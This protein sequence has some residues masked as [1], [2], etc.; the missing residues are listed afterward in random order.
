MKKSRFMYS[1][2]V[3]NESHKQRIQYSKNINGT[4]S[5]SEAVDTS[6]FLL[7]VTGHRS[8]F[9]QYR[10]Y[11]KHLEKLTLG[12]IRPKQIF[13]RPKVSFDKCLRYFQC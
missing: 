11:L 5:L 1:L 9:Y 2:L 4:A 12:L 8:L 13:F 7:Q 10:K 6:R 3:Y